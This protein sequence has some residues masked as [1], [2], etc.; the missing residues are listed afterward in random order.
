MIKYNIH[1]T[2]NEI[3][4]CFTIFQKERKSKLNGINIIGVI[5]GKNW[6]TKKDKPLVIG[7]HWDTY[8]ASGGFNDNGASLAALLE[9]AR[10][11]ASARCFSPIHSILFVAFDA[12]EAGCAGSKE[13]ISS[14]IRP[15]KMSKGIEIQGAIILDTIFNYDSE[16]SSQHFSKVI[17]IH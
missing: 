2:R 16:V 15:L 1:F 11:L 9:S 12:E 6:N 8:G 17:Y 3:L 10:V 14:Y 13:F 5:P 7:A 4:Y